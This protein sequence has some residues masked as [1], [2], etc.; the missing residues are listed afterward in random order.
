ML[1]VSVSPWIHPLYL[2]NVW[3]N[4]YETW[5]EYHGSWAH[6][7]GILH[8]F[9]PP[10]WVS[11]YVALQSLLGNGSVKILLRQRIS[12]QHS[13]IFYAVHVV[14]KE[15]RRLVHAKT[16]GCRIKCLVLLVV[17]QRNVPARL[18]VSK[19]VAV[20]SSELSGT[21]SSNFI[22]FLILNIGCS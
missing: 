15:S 7:S 22:V 13:V 1:C 17:F 19:R 20:G 9:R 16:S 12:T 14:W 11:V 5:Y 4:L 8:K 10:I 18:L 6:L 2:L 21:T 3:S